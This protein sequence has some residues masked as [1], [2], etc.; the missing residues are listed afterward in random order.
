MDF[1]SHISFSVSDL[2]KSI[3]FY[4]AILG[5]L[6][7]QRMYT[8]T[9]GAGWGPEPGRE[10]FEIKKR[11]EKAITPSTGTDYYAAFVIDPDGYELEVKVYV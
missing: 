8:G 10:V 3:E 6:G 9:A 5:E 2:Q 7:H 4:D 11:V 1:I